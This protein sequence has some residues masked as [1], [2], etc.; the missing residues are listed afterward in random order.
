MANLLR[1]GFPA[2]GFSTQI[3]IFGCHL[4]V[5]V[6]FSFKWKNLFFFVK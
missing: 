1:P 6:Y 4:G 5:W 2:L 3:W